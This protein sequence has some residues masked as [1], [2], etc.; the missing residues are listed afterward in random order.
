MYSLY[1]FVEISNFKNNTAGQTATVGELSAIGRTFSTE[2]GQYAV[3]TYPDV[4]LVSIDSR[5]DDA[6]VDVG[7]TYYDAALHISQWL[8]DRSINGL[9]GN[10]IVAIR[11]A[12]NAQF[13]AVANIKEVGTVLT[14]GGRYYFPAYLT[15]TFTNTGE[16]ND[17]YLWYSDTYFT[18]T[19]PYPLYEFRALLPMATID[20]LMAAPETAL[21]AL[22]A[23][24][25]ASFANNAQT[26]AGD[27]PYTYLWSNE[28]D[29]YCLTNSD[30][31]YQCPLGVLINSFAGVNIDHI[32]DALRAYILANSAHNADDWRKVLPQLFKSTEFYLVPMWD[33]KSLQNQDEST[34]LYSPTARLKDAIIK[35]YTDKYMFGFS[36]AWLDANLC[37]SGSA[38]KNLS[39]LSVGNQD[40]YGAQYS[41]DLQF[42]EYAAINSLSTEFSKIPARVRMF[43]SQLFDLFMACEVATATSLVPAGFT[44][45]VRNEI[46][47]LTF[48][49]ESCQYLCPIRDGFTIGS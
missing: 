32:Q 5:R 40:N 47:Y 17:I 14:Q 27:K 37:L 3:A 42:P 21:A 38:Y 7:L 45:V 10:D 25:A 46:S 8:Y 4:Q 19:Q 30:I 11:Q 6:L 44:R 13:G 36:A 34:R 24:T 18:Q 12:L 29:W 22:K 20:T 16:D 48:T 9:L 2:I 33:R 15:L 28:Y 31:T 35:A 43:I 1:G 26:V 39:F 49:Y 41:F 23:V